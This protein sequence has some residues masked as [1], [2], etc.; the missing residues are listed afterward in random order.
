PDATTT[1]IRSSLNPSVV[2]N[3]VTFT[4]TVR[5]STPGS[6]IATGIVTFKDFGNVL[7]TGAVDGTGVATFTTS[8]LSV[9]NHAITAVYAGDTNFTGS[10]SIAF[11]QTVKSSPALAVALNMNSESPAVS[12]GSPPALVPSPTLRARIRGLTGA[13][14]DHF[15]AWAPVPL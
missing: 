5:A 2:G 11:G 12:F 4:A 6:G 7:G 9:G 15:F 8:S 3:T 10:T 1:G 14:V 13:E